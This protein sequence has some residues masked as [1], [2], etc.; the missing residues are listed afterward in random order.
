[1]AVAA[2]AAMTSMASAQTL[3][4]VTV[5]VPNGIGLTDTTA[6]LAL[7]MELGYF[8]D[9]GIEL[10]LVNFR[11]TAVLLPQVANKTIDIGWGPPDIAIAG[12]QPDRDNVPVRFFYNW[13]RSSI[14]EFV[15]LEESPI[16]SLEDLKGQK[17][18]VNFLSGGQIPQTKAILQSAGLDVG[19]NVDLIATGYGPPAF[20]ALTSGQVQALALFEGQHVTL[21]NR[22][23]KLRRLKVP[24]KYEALFTDGFYAHDDTI[25][26]KGKMLAGFGRAVSKGMV[27]CEANPD[28]CVRTLW[29]LIPSRKPTEGGDEKN[30]ADSVRI[31]KARF[32]RLFFFEPNTKPLFGEFP[33][34]PWRDYLQLLKGADQIKSADIPLTNLYT[35]EFVPAFNDFDREKVRQQALSLK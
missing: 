12:K 15:V 20:L 26:N 13:Y 27:A 29:K 31:M 2:L 32:L 24:A 35:N 21:E 9:E 10:D 23:T 16:K 25:K 1:M 4:K 17:V 30:L 22:G 33:E 14:W 3:Q 8:K 5:G 18:G 11:G 7:S 34:Q 6:H 19:R 28:A